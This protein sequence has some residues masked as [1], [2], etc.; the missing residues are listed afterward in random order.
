MSQF[1]EKNHSLFPAYKKPGETK[2]KCFL[3]KGAVYFG[4]KLLGTFAHE[5]SPNDKTE[6]AVKIFRN[7][8]ISYIPLAEG[9]M[10]D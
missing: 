6:R 9:S 5:G 4:K 8:L 10:A 1:T 2:G 3:V 7:R